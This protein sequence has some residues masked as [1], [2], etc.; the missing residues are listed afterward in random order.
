MKLIQMIPLHLIKCT[1]DQLKFDYPQYTLVISQ[2]YLKIY[3]QIRG[4]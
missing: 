3:E 2:D 1:L 4:F